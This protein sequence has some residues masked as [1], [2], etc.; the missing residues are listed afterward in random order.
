MAL[1]VAIHQPHYLP[2]PGLLDKLDQADLFIWLDDAAFTRGGWQ[3]RNWIKT[4]DGRRLLTAPVLHTGRQE[5]LTAARLDYTLAWQTKHRATIK[6]AYARAPHL[7]LCDDLL[8]LLYAPGTWPTLADLNLA[9]STELARVL[10]IR[11][12]TIRS[13][14]LRPAR[15]AKTA[16]LVELC[17][18]VGATT[19]LAGDGSRTRYLDTALF[20]E[21]GITVQW[22]NYQPPAYPQQHPSQGTL[23]NLSA[24]DLIANLGPDA[25]PALRAARRAPAPAVAA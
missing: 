9:C 17:R 7:D 8:H 22:Q 25:L 18:E 14:R 11:T 3:N 1:T 16:R 12:P 24:L 4:H 21:A 15:A 23:D 5:R 6:Q 2:Y 19:Y 10:D 20:E 13:S